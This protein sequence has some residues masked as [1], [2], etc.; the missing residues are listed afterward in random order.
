MT[1]TLSDFNDL[2]KNRGFQSLHETNFEFIGP[3]GNF[4]EYD[5]VEQIVKIADI[6]KAMGLSNY[7]QARFPIK[8]NLNLPAS[9][10]I[11]YRFSRLE[12][13]SEVWFSSISHQS[14]SNP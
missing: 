14:R 7:K 4:C 11:H 6:I 9:G 5:T 13:F 10:K 12:V 1:P 8:S 2:D 3:D